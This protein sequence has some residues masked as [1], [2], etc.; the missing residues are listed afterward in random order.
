MQMCNIG[1]YQR[2]FL[3]AEGWEVLD[4]TEVKAHAVVA[5]PFVPCPVSLSSALHEYFTVVPS[6]AHSTRWALEFFDK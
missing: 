3:S 1:S 5:Y 6:A 2:S 4:R